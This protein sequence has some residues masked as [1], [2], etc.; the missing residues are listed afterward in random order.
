MTHLEHRGQLCDRPWQG[1]IKEN[2]Q[3]MW[4]LSARDLFV[5]RPHRQDI[6]E[7]FYGGPDNLGAETN[8]TWR[9]EEE[10][11][12]YFNDIQINNEQIEEEQE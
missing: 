8:R 6:A 5:A 1:W 10:Y 12:A 4:T 7:Y 9:Q 2:A 3:R 11:A